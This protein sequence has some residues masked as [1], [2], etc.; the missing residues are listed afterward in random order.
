VPVESGSNFLQ[1]GPL[2]RAVPAAARHAHHLRLGRAPAILVQIAAQ[3]GSAAHAAR[4]Q[5]LPTRPCRSIAAPSGHSLPEP[6]VADIAQGLD[7]APRLGRCKSVSQMANPPAAHPMRLNTEELFLRDVRQATCL[8]APRTYQNAPT[9]PT[10]SHGVEPRILIGRPSPSPDTSAFQH[11]Q[12][13]IADLCL[14]SS[15]SIK[16]PALGDGS[17]GRVRRV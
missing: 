1:P 2:P 13:R 8:R 11:L 9:A 14:R 17:V 15:V 7:P 10:M 5:Q 12:R 4:G 6:L 16:A 3:P